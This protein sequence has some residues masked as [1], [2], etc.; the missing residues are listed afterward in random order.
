MGCVPIERIGAGEPVAGA[1]RDAARDSLEKVALKETGAEQ[2]DLFRA[3]CY[4]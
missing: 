1:H 3:P 2:N 4:V